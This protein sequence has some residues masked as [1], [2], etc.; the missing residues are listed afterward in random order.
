MGRRIKN[1]ILEGG[2]TKDQYIGKVLSKK[3]GLDC[4]QISGELGKK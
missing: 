1:T 4:L 2:F 3:E